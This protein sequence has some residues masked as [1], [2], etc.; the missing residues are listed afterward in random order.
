M[1]VAGYT[2][3]RNPFTP[4]ALYQ[5]H[6]ASGGYPRLI[7]TMADQALI[8]GMA[9]GER[10]IDAFLMHDVCEQHLGVAA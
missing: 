8:L 9:Q 2:G 7:S 3:E 6:K 5:L 4:D 10:L 1:R